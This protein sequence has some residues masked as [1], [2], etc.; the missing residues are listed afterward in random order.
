MAVGDRAHDGAYGEAV[1]VV[2]NKDEDAQREGGQ[3]GPHPGLDVPLRPPAKGRR[4]AGGVDQGH[5]DAQQH[6][7]EE[8]AGVALNGGD[9]A[10]GEHGVQGLHGGEAALEQGAHQHADEQGGVGLLGDEGQDD[11]HHRGHQGPEGCIHAG[12]G[13]LAAGG[14]CGDSEA[15]AGRNGQDQGQCSADSWGSHVRF[16]LKSEFSRL[17]RRKNAPSHDAIM[18][19]RNT[20]HAPS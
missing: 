14:E 4:A 17:F 11:G 19:G 16:L 18:T 6:Q 1:E 13:V 3:G 9:K 15:Q 2:V 5:D 8:D 10:L 20:H 7:E 12:D